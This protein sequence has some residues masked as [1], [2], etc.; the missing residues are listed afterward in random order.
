MSH[1]A[2]HTINSA[3]AGAKPIL[4]QLQE[5]VGF[6]PNLAAT[7]A[8]SPLVLETWATLGGIFGRSTFSP[9]ER[10]IVAMATSYDNRC[11]YAMAAHSTF[12]KAYGASEAVLEA[13]RAGKSPSD[14]RIGALVT[15]THQVVRGRG[16]VPADE[17][18]AFLKAGFTEAQ[19]LDV[20]IGV[21]QATL[22]SFVHTM[23]GT[24]LDEGFR[25]QEW[26]ENT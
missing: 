3:P 24:P 11:T 25:P 9:A 17:L 2:I 12:A 7:M 23:A 4:E 26:G 13:V 20:L 21:S 18:E 5:R 1:F 19:A 10:E 14:P 15:F 8:G 16:Q 6:V 22:A